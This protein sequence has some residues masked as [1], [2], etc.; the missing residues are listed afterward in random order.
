VFEIYFYHIPPTPIHVHFSHMLTILKFFPCDLSKVLI[1]SP[2]SC[3]KRESIICSCRNLNF[4]GVS[5]VLIF[6]N[7]FL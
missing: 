3:T 1:F 2:I 7:F 4:E 6:F 5:K